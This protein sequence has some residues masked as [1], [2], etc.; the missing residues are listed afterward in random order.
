MEGLRSWKQSL[1]GSPWV[2]AS[3]THREKQQA[4]GDCLQTAF[5]FSSDHF[6][7]GNRVKMHN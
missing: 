7:R 6:L 1:D 4:M 3:I 2:G 5:L